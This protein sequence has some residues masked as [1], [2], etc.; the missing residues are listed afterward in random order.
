MLSHLDRPEILAYL[1][2]PRKSSTGSVP[3]SSQNIDFTVAED[4][5]LGC[6]LFTADKQAPVLL[7]FHG[8]G[9]IV[10][11]YNDIAPMYTHQGI[12]FLVTDYRGYGWSTGTPTTSA[13]IEDGRV[14][15]QKTITWL[16]ENDYSGDI[17]IM[18]RSM[19]SSVAIDLAVEFADQIKGIV[20]ES[21]FARTI[22]LAKT[23]GLN[24][25]A[26]GLT[27]EDGF[28]NEEKI[29][30]V[31]TPTFILHGQNDTLIEVWQAEALHAACAAKSKELQI[32]PGADHNS[33]IAV[34]G[35]LYFQAIKRFV[36]KVTGADDWRKRRR[37]HKRS[38][39]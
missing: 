37:H 7:F 26:L 14:I 17:I 32:V 3:E 16:Q 13:L 27:E 34:G 8:N 28:Q 11:D 20:I 22:P 19:G 30:K 33:L 31:K 1:F 29:S 6:R 21:G 2:H 10:D 15:L 5:T 35:I 9:E 12:N 23:L 4:V 18:G 24:P 25:E 36:D 38:T 39:S